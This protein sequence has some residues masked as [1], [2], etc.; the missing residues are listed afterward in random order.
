MYIKYKKNDVFERHNH[1][2]TLLLRVG[3]YKAGIKWYIK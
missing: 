2:G 1:S 3:S